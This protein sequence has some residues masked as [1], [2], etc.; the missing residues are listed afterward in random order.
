MAAKRRLEQPSFGLKV[1][2]VRSNYAEAPIP[3]RGIIIWYEKSRDLFHVKLETS[4]FI[5]AFKKI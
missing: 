5:Q 3:K 1:M 4:S 2:T